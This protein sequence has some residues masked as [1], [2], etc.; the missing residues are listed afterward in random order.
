MDLS[1]MEGN[2]HRMAASCNRISLG[3]G[4]DCKVL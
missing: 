1:E 4:D 2:G 3:Y